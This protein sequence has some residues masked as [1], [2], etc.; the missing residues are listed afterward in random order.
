MAGIELTEWAFVV[1]QLKAA[2]TTTKVTTSTDQT[3]SPYDATAALVK[4]QGKACLIVANNVE[5]G[6]I[7]EVLKQLDLFAGTPSYTTA[8][9]GFT[10][11]LTND[12]GKM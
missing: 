12:K 7:V 2:L 8:N 9:V 1:D 6:Q 11:E 5:K 3:D 4:T 10:V